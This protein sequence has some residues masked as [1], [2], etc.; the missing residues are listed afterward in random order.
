VALGRAIAFGEA[1]CRDHRQTQKNS[2]AGRKKAAEAA[3]NARRRAKGKPAEK[4][5]AEPPARCTVR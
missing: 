1:L 4:A 5:K 2:V 3:A